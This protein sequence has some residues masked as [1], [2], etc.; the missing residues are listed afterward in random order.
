[1]D[2]LLAFF[3]SKR[4]NGGKHFVGVVGFAHDSAEPPEQVAYIDHFVSSDP[5]SA[6]TALPPAPDRLHTFDFAGP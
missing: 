1:L 2:G 6:A 3:I 5:R 4:Q